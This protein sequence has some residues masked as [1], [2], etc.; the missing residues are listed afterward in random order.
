MK[1]SKPKHQI[2]FRENALKVELSDAAILE[3]LAE[4]AS[5][6]AKAALKLARILREE[7]P[8]PV[9][10]EEGLKNLEEETADVT[11]CIKAIGLYE[12]HQVDEIVKEKY[13]RL[14]ERLHSK[15]LEDGGLQYET[16]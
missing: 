8:T 2:P 14:K 12:N 1:W 13:R 16:L 6:L 3:A 4:E 5:E 15:T 10:F 7:N 9:S 11:L